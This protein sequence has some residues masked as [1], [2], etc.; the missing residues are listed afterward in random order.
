M[1]SDDNQRRRRRTIERIRRIYFRFVCTSSAQ[2]IR[3]ASALRGCFVIRTA[4]NLDREMSEIRD[5]EDS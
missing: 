4:L 1:L 5:A 3:E 2:T